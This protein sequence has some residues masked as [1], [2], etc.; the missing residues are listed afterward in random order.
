MAQLPTE[1]NKP[2]IGYVPSLFRAKRPGRWHITAGP[3]HF[4]GSSINC[5]ED[6]ASLPLPEI[7]NIR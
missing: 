4:H 1:Q 6:I 2:D 5:Q 7:F 3:A